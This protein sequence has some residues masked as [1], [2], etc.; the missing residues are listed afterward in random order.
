MLNQ[1]ISKKFS[2]AKAMGIFQLNSIKPRV[3]AS[4]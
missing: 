3:V 4:W 2:L 1:F